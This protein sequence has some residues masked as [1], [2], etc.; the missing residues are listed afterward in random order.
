MA[1][2]RTFFSKILLFNS[3]RRLIPEETK[4][5]GKKK[6]SHSTDGE[7]EIEDY[8][9][10]VRCGAEREERGSTRKRRTEEREAAEKASFWPLRRTDGIRRSGRRGRAP[11]RQAGRQYGADFMGKETLLPLLH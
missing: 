3:G 2:R 11:D 4:T 7:K 1:A 10:C 9:L 6:N 8:I 5:P